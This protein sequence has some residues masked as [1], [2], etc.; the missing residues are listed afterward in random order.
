MPIKK[1]ALEKKWYYRIAKIFFLWVFPILVAA[2][3]F[4]VIYSDMSVMFPGDIVAT[5][6]ANSSYIIGIAIGLGLYFLILKG[7]WRGFL[8]I[9][10]G[11]L[12]DDMQ[13]K[14]TEPVQSAGPTVPTQAP[15]KPPTKV[16]VHGI[17]QACISAFF[18]FLI[19]YLI[20]YSYN[21]ATG[22]N[23]DNG[24]QMC[25]SIYQFFVGAFQ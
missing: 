6:Q 9:A 13:K 21:C 5:I 12:E 23:L 14:A 2:A 25:Q 16:V 1:S 19:L 4:L 7:I 20:W 8:Y 18:G 10:F 11:G 3:L 24:D 17:I 22:K 15:T